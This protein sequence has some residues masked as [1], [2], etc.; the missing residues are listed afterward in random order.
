MH[1]QTVIHYLVTALTAVVVTGYL[2]LC[3]W[4]WVHQPA[5]QYAP[6]G[7]VAAPGTADFTAITAE[8]G[9]GS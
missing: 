5:V 1:R 8:D 7:T 9:N 4:F 2:G 6:G 3:G